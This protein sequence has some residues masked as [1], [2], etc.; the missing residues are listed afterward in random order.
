[1][2]YMGEAYQDFEEKIQQHG[3]QVIATDPTEGGTHGEQKLEDSED[4]GAR[5]ASNSKVHFM[6]SSNISI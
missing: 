6:L 3:G 1:M 4:Q 2:K 5:K